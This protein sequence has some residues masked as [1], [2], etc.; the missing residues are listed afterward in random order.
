MD[1]GHIYIPFSG[2]HKKYF[3]GILTWKEKLVPFGASLEEV[4]KEL[5]AVSHE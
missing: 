2:I 1:L 4:V 5:K 3:P